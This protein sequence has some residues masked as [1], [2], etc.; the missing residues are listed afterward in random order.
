MR[1]LE[2]YQTTEKTCRTL[3]QSYMLTLST[4]IY[5]K[6]EHFDRE[7]VTIKAA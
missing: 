4:E 2:K 6:L 1:L 7:L 3:G 5:A